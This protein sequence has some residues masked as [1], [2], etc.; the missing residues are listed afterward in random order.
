M[1]ALR[2]WKIGQIQRLTEGQK[3]AEDISITGHQTSPRLSK[4]EILR[5][6]IMLKKV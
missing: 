4:G 2:S 5:A 6:L 3:E 1:W